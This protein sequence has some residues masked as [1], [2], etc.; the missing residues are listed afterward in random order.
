ML[1][2]RMNELG[3]CSAHLFSTVWRAP[4]RGNSRSMS[5]TPILEHERQSSGMRLKRTLR[6][7]GTLDPEVSS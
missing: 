2:I 7:A 5:I 4:D 3:W 1:D 6:K